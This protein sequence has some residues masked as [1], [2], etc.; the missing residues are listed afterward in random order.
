MSSKVA[1][2]LGRLF[3]V[4]F[5]IGILAYIKEKQITHR[6]DN[7]YLEELQQLKFPQM[8]KRIVSQV[9]STL[10][11]EMVQKW[12]TFYLQKGFF[13]G[14]NFFAEYLQSIGW[15]EPRRIGKVEILYYQCQFCGDNSIGTYEGKNNVGWFKELLS[16]LNITSDEVERYSEEYF[17]KDLDLGKKG[18]FVNADT[19]MLLRCRKEVRILCVDL[20]VFSIKS[21]QEVKNLDFVEILRNL[22]IRDISYLRSKSVFSQLRI[23]TQSLGFEFNDDLKSYF[24]AF[25]YKDKESAKLIQA[26]GYAYSFYNF[27]KDNN[28]INHESITFNAVGYSDRGVSA[29]SVK[30]ENLAVLKNCYEI[31]TDDSSS[32][33]INEARKKVLYRV[34]RSAYSSFI[35]GKNFVDALLD[36][37]F[38]NTTTVTHQERVEGFFNSVGQVPQY[39]MDKLELTGTLDLRNA[40]AELIKRELISDSN[41]IF[42]TGNPGIGK[43]TAIANFLKSHVDEGFLFFYVSPRK[44]VNLDIIEKFKDKTS[45]KL[46]DDRILAINSYS[47][48]IN[49]NQGEYTV[50]YLSNQRQGDFRSQSVHFCDS[51]NVE[52]RLRRSD[53]LNRKNYDTIQDAEKSSKGVLNSICEAIS[54]VI[55]RQTSHNIIA[56]ASIQSLKKSFDGTDTLKHFEKIFRNAYNDREGIVI[57]ERMQAISNKIK[58][59]FIMID[60]ITGDDSGV[61]FLHGIHQILSKYKL[62]DSQHGFNLKVI[63]ADASIVDKNVINQHLADKTAEPDKI[64]FRRTDDTSEPLSIEHFTFKDLPSTVINTNSYPAKSLTITY[65]AIVESQL[66]IDQLKDKNSLTKSLQKEILQDIQ[67]L[68][69]RSEVEQ[70][71]VYIQDKQRLGELIE[72]IERQREFKPFKDYIEIHANISE[73][74]K[75][76]INQ[77]KNDV[78]IVFMTASGSRGLSF[79][80]AKH[81]LVE[82]PGFQIE[83]NLMEVIQVIYRGRGDDKIDNQDKELIFYLAQKSVYYQDDLENQQLAI[84]ESVLS[85]L[86]I[87]L[88]LKASINTRIFGHGNIGREKFIIIPIGGKSIFTAGG[89]FSAQIANLIKQLKQEHRR[90]KSDILVEQV[91]TN[92]EK[93]LG[94]ADFTVRDSTDFNYLDLFKTFNNS[95]AKICSSLD[96]LLDFGNL[97]LAYISGSLLIVP[98]PNNALEENYQMRVLD[99]ATYANEQLWQNMQIISRRKT[100]PENLRFAIKDGIELINKLQEE[101]NKTQNLEQLSQNSDQYYALPLFTFI[102]GEVLKEYFTNE[103][104]EP[105]DGRFRDILATYI[106]SLYPVNNILPI[107]DGYREFPFVLFRSYSLAEIRKKSFTDKY[108]LTSNELNVLNLI[109]S[110]QP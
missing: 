65:K 92:L 29:M 64:Y 34:R 93:L 96:K 106:R 86:N 50:Q 36:I 68:L 9:I 102:S 53:K 56:T 109:L 97:E 54:T 48:L 24:T 40:H 5:N 6:F 107:G 16:Q 25:K 27:L 90:N 85:L 59:L 8:L 84:Q 12:S 104:E 41:Y 20:S 2:E 19:L 10:E 18:E 79:P 57:P 61:E 52:L 73:S 11:R 83:K 23:D 101:V 91:Y 35:K 76:Q 26:G 81:L 82:I 72:K 88:I 63:I 37:P 42:L 30:P 87:L 38:N 103:P 17:R 110:K 55:E 31:Y 33:D 47:N 89:T 62:T 99:I 32:K 94:T 7:L 67:A 105:E 98:I 14:L 39:L 70:I 49:D 108:L 46:C 21:D 1:E 28:I 13:C 3:E 75:E 60:E 4:G 100:Y 74:E 69:N 44:Q 51:R 80:Q 43:T 22:L 66:Y 78:K 95:F 71:I 45:N 58:H 77:C 15:N